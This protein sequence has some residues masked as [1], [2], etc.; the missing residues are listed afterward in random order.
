MCPKAFL[1]EVAEDQMNLDNRG[2]LLSDS[3]TSLMDEVTGFLT[4]TTVYRKFTTH[5]E[6]FNAALI[7]YVLNVV[8]RVA[9]GIKVRAKTAT[10]TSFMQLRTCMLSKA[11]RACASARQ[12]TWMTCAC[13]MV[14]HPC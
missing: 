3:W 4:M 7:T 13:L 10:S 11:R 9:L 5:P 6:I 12:M 14:E 2:N 8:M 1:C